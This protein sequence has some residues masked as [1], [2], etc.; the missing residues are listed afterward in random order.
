MA[1]GKNAT[2]TPRSAM[3]CAI[4]LGL[5]RSAADPVSAVA[6]AAS[7]THVSMTKPSQSTGQKPAIDHPGLIPTRSTRTSAK[8]DSDPRLTWTA[9]GAAVVPEVK[10]T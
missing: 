6:P 5:A 3:N 8:P 2:S 7:G 10:H 1:V 9:L 4:L